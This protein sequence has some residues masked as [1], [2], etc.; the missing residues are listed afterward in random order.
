MVYSLEFIVYA[1]KNYKSNK[2]TYVDIKSLSKTIAVIARMCAKLNEHIL[3]SPLY[4]V[5]I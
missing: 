5:P 2:F 3:G 1:K 4:D